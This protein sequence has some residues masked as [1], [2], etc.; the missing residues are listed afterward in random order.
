[1]ERERAG[2]PLVFICHSAPENIYCSLFIDRIQI[3]STPMSLNTDRFLRSLSDGVEL[4]HLQVAP[5]C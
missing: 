5:Q 4:L 1:M 2:L 3:D